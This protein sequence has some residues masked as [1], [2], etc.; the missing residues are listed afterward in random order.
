MHCTVVEGCSPSVVGRIDFEQLV[1]PFVIGRIAVPF[2]LAVAGKPC[3]GFAVEVVTVAASR[4]WE[5]DL[6]ERHIREV[7]QAVLQELDPL[8]ELCGNRLEST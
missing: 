4:C 1:I 3:W 6:E 8:E 5:R 2:A 7:V